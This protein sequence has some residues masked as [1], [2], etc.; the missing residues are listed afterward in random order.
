MS[1][2]LFYDD[3]DPRGYVVDPIKSS[4]N[5]TFLPPKLHFVERVSQLVKEI[6]LISDYTTLLSKE[7]G[8]TSS[9]QAPGAAGA[10]TLKKENH[11]TNLIEIATIY[12]N[13]L[14]MIASGISFATGFDPKNP[15]NWEWK[16]NLEQFKQSANSLDNLSIQDANSS[17][18][19]ELVNNLRSSGVEILKIYDNYSKIMQILMD[20]QAQVKFGRILKFFE[21]TDDS[22]Q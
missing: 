21:Q 18:H 7:K 9:V 14:Q 3:R 19:L 5:Q 11:Y 15:N 6:N 22:N 13:F 17:T 16:K 1:L 4:K 12:K 8:K 2:K 20:N 10:D